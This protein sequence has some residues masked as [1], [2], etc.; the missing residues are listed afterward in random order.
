V[1]LT[2]IKGDVFE[3][4]IVEY[5]FPYID[6]EPY[7]S[8]WL[9]VQIQCRLDGHTWVATDSLLTWEV[10]R[11]LKR[12]K[13]VSNKELVRRMQFG[14]TEPY[15]SFRLVNTI[16]GQKLWVC[17]QQWFRPSW[18][19]LP[20]VDYDDDFHLEFSLSEIS[21]DRV[22]NGIQGQFE[23]FPIRAKHTLLPRVLP[24]DP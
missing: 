18:A 6:N 24:P 11:L 22:L 10:E 21:F 17:L 8:N 4:K 15:L 16:E 9:V 7:D 2:N 5:Y 14:F 23:R 1:R 20:Y 13:K 12:F 19:Y 3:L